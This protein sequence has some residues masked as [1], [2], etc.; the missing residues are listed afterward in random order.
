MGLWGLGVDA[1]GGAYDLGIAE[2]AGNRKAKF[3][4][5][6]APKF[7][8]CHTLRSAEVGNQGR[9]PALPGPQED[10]FHLRLP[11]VSHTQQGQVGPPHSLL[12]ERLGEGRQQS[13]GPKQGQLRL[14][15]ECREGRFLRN[16]LEAPP[17]HHIGQNWPTATPAHT[18]PQTCF[19]LAAN[20]L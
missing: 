15:V 1:G 6:I 5:L 7:I 10:S 9:S 16:F 18:E 19:S 4:L 2:S 3:Q 13:Q 8:F 20:G 12:P 17:V 14:G 11:P